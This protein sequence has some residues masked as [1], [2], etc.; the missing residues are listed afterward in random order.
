MNS[1]DAG[2]WEQYANRLSG[3]G[4]L[5]VQLDCLRLHLPAV[6]R[7]RLQIPIGGEWMCSLW[8][9]KRL[10]LLPECLWPQYLERTR[11]QGDDPLSLERFR[12]LICKPAQRVRLDAGGRWSLRAE[13]VRQASLEAS[14]SCILV[15]DGPVIEVWDAAARRQLVASL[16]GIDTQLT[17]QMPV[18][19]ADSPKTPPSAGVVSGNPC[20]SRRTRRKDR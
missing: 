13:L 12:E 4:E 15:A 2:L 17:H 16:I 18:C 19:P 8:R 10:R 1:G 5:E 20:I 6:L 14:R 7:R 3:M 11:P 9:V